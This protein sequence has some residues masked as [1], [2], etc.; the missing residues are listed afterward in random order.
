MTGSWHLVL[1]S[2]REVA[3]LSLSSRGQSQLG[4]SQALQAFTP[5]SELTLGS[6]A[7]GRAAL[8]FLQEES[9][10]IHREGK[11]FLSRSQIPERTLE[12]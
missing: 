1:W 4:F 3:H 10:P 5:S 2:L 11:V 8:S 7:W 12:T 9:P 6:Q